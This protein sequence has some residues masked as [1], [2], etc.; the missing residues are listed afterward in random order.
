MS[1]RFE[2]GFIG[3]GNMGR[4]LLEGLI[5]KKRFPPSA[6]A[7]SVP[8]PARRKLLQREL[9]LRTFHSNADLVKRSRRIVLAV[10]PR[11]M[12]GVLDE[13]RGEIQGS[14]LL[15]TLAAGLETSYYLRRLP[16]H[17]RLI[18]A[19]P[20]LPVSVGEGATVLFA[21][22]TARRGDRGFAL[23]TFSTLGKTFFIEKE[24]LLDAVTALSACGPA[25]VALFLKGLVSG[26]KRLGL[27]E[28]VAH[29]LALQTL[30]GTARLVESSK[31][32]YDDLAGRVASKG[33]STEAG[34]RLLKKRKGEEIIAETVL[35]AGRRAKRLKEGI[36]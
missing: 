12:G 29:T 24:Q 7:A 15:I 13:I 20:N 16:Q 5:Q 32:S 30:I 35:A 22:P 33:G 9:S 27:P 17:T 23:K 36:R 28:K 25:F 18:R 26:G 1:K 6:L 21:A 10:K 4:A 8:H 11:E 19:M 31:F 2:L 3:A 34:L 14:H